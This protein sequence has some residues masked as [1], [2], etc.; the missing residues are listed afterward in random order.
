MMRG[1]FRLAIMATTVI[2]LLVGAVTVYGAGASVQFKICP[3]AAA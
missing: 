2:A 1:R 3:E